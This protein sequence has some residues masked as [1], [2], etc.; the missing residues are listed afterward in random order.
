MISNAR[1]TGENPM[2]KTFVLDTSALIHDPSVWNQFPNS[3]VM[4]PIET[5]NELDKL[6]KGSNEA[7]RSARVCIRNLDEISNAGDISSGVQLENDILLK[8]DANYVNLSSS[9]FYN[10]GDPTY[11][12]TKILACLYTTWLRHTEHDVTLVSNDINLRVKAKA[13]GINAIACEGDKVN[14][15]DL[16]SG[17][18]IVNDEEIAADLLQNDVIDPRC[19]GLKLNPNECVVFLDSNGDTICLGR[20]ISFDR[21]KW[22]KGQYPWDIKPRNNEQSLAIDLIMDRNVDLVTF[23]GIAGCGKSL[24]TLACGLELVL[25]KRQYDKFVIYRPIQPVGSDIGYLPGS[26]SEKLEPHFAAIMDNFETLFTG[27]TGKDYKKDEW[28]KDDWK[29][30]LEMYQEKGRIEMQAITY[31][32][33]RSIHNSIM[34]IDECQN[35]SKSEVKTILTR[36]GEGTKIILNGD[37]QQIDQDK[38]D[39]TNNGLTYVVE[40]FKES[41]IAGHINF[42]KGERS[43][44]A[45]IA[46]EIL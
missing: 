40:S 4:L 26:V 25:E 37:I 38:L 23:T 7:A 21:L 29:R 2:R 12:D 6:K 3:D 32:R 9:T 24:L 28:K 41:E 1:I 33:G 11:G 34:L 19:Y 16:Y 44:L 8:I 18:Q 15:T 36:A 20:K 43:R 30:G 14:A 22:V 5:L 10:L 35:L 13:R 27:K 45:T 17:M 39:A 42:T 31:I 46:S